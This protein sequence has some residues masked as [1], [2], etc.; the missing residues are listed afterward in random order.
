M[1]LLL[2]PTICMLSLLFP[3]LLCGISRLRGKCRECWHQ[4]GCYFGLGSVDEMK[5]FGV[6]L[7]W[8][9]DISMSA[10]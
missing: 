9:V 10:L 1:I 8:L 3:Q 2:L 6:F 5:S 4:P 7:E